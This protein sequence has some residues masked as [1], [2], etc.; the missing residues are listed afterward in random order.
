[1]QNPVRYMDYYMGKI[2]RLEQLKTNLA[3]VKRRWANVLNLSKNSNGGLPHVTHGNQLKKQSSYRGRCPL[4][5][6]FPA[7]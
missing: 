1:M 6:Q 2:L 5:T 4:I 3:S 7:I